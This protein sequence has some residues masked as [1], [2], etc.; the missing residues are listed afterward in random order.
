MY[1]WFGG[2]GLCKKAVDTSNV[3]MVMPFWDPSVNIARM[4]SAD[5]VPDESP[6]WAAEPHAI[7]CTTS[8]IRTV[9]MASDPTASDI[10]VIFGLMTQR[11]PMIFTPSFKQISLAS[12]SVNKSPKRTL[13]SAFNSVNLPCLARDISSVWEPSSEMT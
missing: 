4:L 7:S 12:V 2:M 13:F 8:R 10:C 11:L 3:A 6:K 5:G 9:S 1:R